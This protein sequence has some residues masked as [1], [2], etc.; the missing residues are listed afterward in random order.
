MEETYTTS[1]ELAGFE[2]LALFLLLG[3][4]LTCL[5]CAA[6][7]VSAA[8]VR[9]FSSYARLTIDVF[10]TGL[11]LGLVR[12]TL[13]RE[14]RDTVYIVSD[15]R[16]TKRSPFRI[17]SVA[18]G[19][20]AEFRY[21]QVPLLLRYGIIRYP[22][23]RL[24]I[25][26]RARNCYGLICAL[27]EKIARTGGAVFQE[28]NIAAFKA[29]ARSNESANERL[30]RLMPYGVGITLLLGVADPVIALFL[31]GL[32]FFPSFAWSVFSQFLFIA[33]IAVAE[34]ILA[35]VSRRTAAAGP[36]PAGEADIYLMAGIVAFVLYLSCGILLKAIVPH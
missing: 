7:G 36:R 4:F 8:S 10:L 31:W 1:T 35:S 2:R 30:A 28:N 11:F 16:L 5:F 23:G 13:T 21:V 29:A 32:P 9:M 22:G 27:R 3:L 17:V 12:L 14:M 19:Q 18:Y 26:L 34:T 33:G 25:S 6:A 24:I 20:I 15:D